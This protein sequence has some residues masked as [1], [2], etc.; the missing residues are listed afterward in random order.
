MEVAFAF[1]VFA[2][3]VN[4]SATLR[5]REEE[6]TKKK[7]RNFILYPVYEYSLIESF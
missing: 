1:G 7:D 3:A 5:S 4:P 6:A 2:T